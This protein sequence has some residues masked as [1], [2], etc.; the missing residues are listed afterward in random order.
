MLKNPSERFFFVKDQGTGY[1]KEKRW[2]ALA[3]SCSAHGKH[4]AQSH[5]WHMMIKDISFAMIVHDKKNCQNTNQ[6][7]A[8]VAFRMSGGGR[9]RRFCRVCH[10][11]ISPK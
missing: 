6:I 5:A 4:V 10:N 1:H 2:S 11:V 9:M 7:E 3:E 8:D